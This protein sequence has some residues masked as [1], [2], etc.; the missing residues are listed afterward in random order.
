MELVSR[1]TNILIPRLRR[2]P[3]QPLNDTFT[4]LVMEHIDGESLANRWDSL[5]QGTRNEVIDTLRDYISQLRQ[6]PSSHP[7]PIGPSPRRC[8]GPMFG[9]DRGQ[10][11]FADYEE[12]SGY[13]DMVLSCAAKRIPQLKDSRKFDGSVP[14]VFTHNNLSMDHMILG[15]DNRI[16]IVGWNLAGCYPRWFE[17][18]SM[19]WSAEEKWIPGWEEWKDIVTKVAGDPTEHSQWMHRIRAT[20]KTLRRSVS[21]EWDDTEIVRRFDEC[22]GFPESA[23]EGGYDCVV[24]ICDDMVVKS[25]SNVDGEIPHSQFL[26]MKLVSTYTNILIPRLRRAPIAPLDDDF[27]YFVMGHIDGESLAKRWD[28]LSEETRK[29]VINTLRDYVSQLRQIPTSHPGPV[30]P[31]PR[32]CCGPMFGGRRRQGPFADYEELSHYYNTML[33]CATKHIPQLEDSKKFDDSAPLVFCHNNLS[34]DHILL[35]KDNRVWIVGWNFA[36]FYPQ[37]FEAVSMLHSAEEKCIRGHDIWKD[38]VT[39]V[40]GDPMEHAEWM[41]DIRPTLFLYKYDGKDKHTSHRK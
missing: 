21:D 11:P 10:G 24:K 3:I 16:W 29:D 23:E 40:V 17:S 18:V 22:P 19:L 2:A 39:E 31:S 33:G 28:S 4:Y 27:T 14:L 34:T 36:G 20:L 30:G 7:G 1:Y 12:L 6:I 41:H 25:I 15:K 9:G 13:Y 5:P 35:D 26:A 37:W 8:Y 32:S 38:I